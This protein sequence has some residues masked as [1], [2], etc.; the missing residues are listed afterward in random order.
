MAS[1]VQVADE[2]VEEYK[3]IKKGKKYR[4][5]V[6]HIKDEKKICI[7][8]SGDRDACYQDYL[9]H[10]A[11]LGPDECRYGLYDF[12]FEHACEGAADTKR[13][14]LIL[15][16]WCPDT[17]KIKKKMLYSSSFDAL[18]HSLEGIGKYIQATDMSE[19][20]PECI[21]EKI[22]STARS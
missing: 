3:F 13:S 14:K 8:S 7:D 22:K 5:I 1:G 4:Y 18:K 6:F 10:L 21:L 17:A 11:S 9:D 15:M 16:I 12:E 19:A 2:V 20:A